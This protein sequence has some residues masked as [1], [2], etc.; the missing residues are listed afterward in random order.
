MSLELKIRDTLVTSFLLDLLQILIVNL[1]Q[2]YN[3]RYKIVGQYLEK[4]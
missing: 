2:A 3:I 4:K 1:T